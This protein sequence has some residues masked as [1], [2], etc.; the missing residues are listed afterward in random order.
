MPVYTHAEIAI[1]VNSANNNT[2]D[3]SQIKK[4]FLGKLKRFPNGEKTV[5]ITQKSSSD[6]RSEFDKKVLK[7]SASQLKSYWSRLLFTGK[8]Q[9]PLEVINDKE[10]IELIKN[11]PNMIGFVDTA[12]LSDSVKVVAKM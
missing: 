2:L 10:M 9:P 6:A 11:N 8:G 1:I 7:K 5:P 12:N 3:K 4:I